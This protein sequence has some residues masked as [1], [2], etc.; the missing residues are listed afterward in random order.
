L[1]PTT[2]A[3]INK[4]VAYGINFELGQQ[5][6]G[7]FSCS[8]SRS[9]LVHNHV[10]GTVSCKGKQKS[11]QIIYEVAWNQSQF[12]VTQMSRSHIFV[13][14]ENYNRLES[15]QPTGTS[16]RD[17]S[18]TAGTKPKDPYDVPGIDALMLKSRRG[19]PD[20]APC[21]SESDDDYDDDAF[22]NDIVDKAID[23]LFSQVSH[24]DRAAANDHYLEDDDH[25]FASDDEEGTSFNVDEIEGLDWNPGRTVG[26]KD[27]KCLPRSTTVMPHFNSCFD[28]PTRSFLL[29]FYSDVGK[30]CIRKQH[31]RTREDADYQKA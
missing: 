10:V 12:G 25:L 31:P 15:R 21:S 27:F 24:M 7:Q 30:D 23:R 16:R 8:V 17:S 26:P 18:G 11:G 22:E 29:S 19:E 20:L 6:L 13:G 14:V 9:T 2:D 3:L 1:V 5:I 4:A 28:N